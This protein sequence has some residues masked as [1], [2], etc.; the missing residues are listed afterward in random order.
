[1]CCTFV[2]SKMSNTLIYTGEGQ[3]NGK[4]VH[5]LAY[6]NVAE[7]L[8]N[9]PNA[10]VIPFPASAPMN[11]NNVIDTSKFKDFLRNITDATKI[12]TRGM[13]GGNMAKSASFDLNDDDA[14]VFDVGS[15]TVVLAEK[16][17]QI[18][19]ALSRVPDHKRPAMSY[20]FLSGYEKLYPNQPVAVCCWS[21]T[22]EA[23]PLLWWYE[24]KDSSV[25]FAPT[26]DAHDGNAPDVESMVH[27]DHII[28]A[29]ATIG[30]KGQLVK[31]EDSIPDHVADLLPAMVHGHKMEYRMKN[32][33]VFIATNDVKVKPH[34]AMIKRGTSFESSI[35]QD[36]MY[37]W[38]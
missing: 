10:M 29:G 33:D 5:V 31:Y 9:A 23:E 21:G 8:S 2:E 14:L 20:K 37:G 34:G 32:G 12:R 26:M 17:S 27:T 19:A 16:V 30:G 25:L 15:Y 36:K 6:Q 3:R 35:T 4:T 13:L 38:Y 7:N 28:S 11:E 24:P 18:P 22:L 1:M